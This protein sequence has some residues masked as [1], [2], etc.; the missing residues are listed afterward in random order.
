MPLA[1]LVIDLSPLRSSGP[2][3]VLF[4]VRV[5]SLFA[6]GFRLV[7]LPIQVYAMTGSSF[8]VASVGIV[9]GVASFGGT[10]V[11]GLLADRWDRRR[12]IVAAA[13]I[14]VGVLA[15]FA[16]NAYL[17]APSLG[18]IYLGAAVNGV[19]GT[20]GLIAQQA[21]VPAL[22]GASRVAAAGA[23]FAVTAQFGAMAAPA[24]GGVAI[25]AWGVGPGYAG[26]AVIAAG[27]AVA[28]AFLPP[29]RPAR[30]T[31][32]TSAP[33]DVVEGL[34]FVRRDPLVR[35]LL[36]LGFAQVL[37]TTPLALVPEFTDRVLGGGAALAGLLYTAP[38]IGALP[39]SLTSGWTSHVRGGGPVVLGAVALCGVAVTALGAS[40]GAV[41]AFAAL[42]LLGCGQAIEEILR[43]ALI[44][45]HTPDAL[46]GRVT[47]AWTAQAT[48]G[49]SLG[50]TGLGVAAALAG[51]AVALVVSGLLCVAATV[52]VAVTEPG[53]RA[54]GAG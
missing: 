33:A 5:V 19:A 27:C 53:L 26:T 34:A 7:A 18:P 12:L 28:V 15:L 13:V 22:V 14:E 38:A 23:L 51:P 35:P 44:Q 11:G 4:A 9:N 43:Y 21:A 16:V 54:R 8:L 36:V 40:G 24:L 29:L 50:A 25:S 42:L 1:R 52:A 48:V 49:G 17:P 6:G 45:R 47:A 30:G 31:Q 46:R 20:A 39:A 2:F 10:L 41:A 32:R 3:R 37:F